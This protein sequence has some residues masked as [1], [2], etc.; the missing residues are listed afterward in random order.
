MVFQAFLDFIVL[1]S[2]I[3]FV[4]KQQLSE[5]WLIQPFI[6]LAGFMFTAGLYA[7]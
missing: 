2:W 1:K 5:K 4:R 7:I 6:Y 3:S